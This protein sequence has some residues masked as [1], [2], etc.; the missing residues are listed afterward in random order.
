MR[1]FVALVLTTS[2]IAL[3]ACG[4]DDDRAIKV[5]AA[6][7]LKTAFTAMDSGASFSFAGSDQLAGQIR[8]G[9]RPDVFAAANSKLPDA[10]YKEG[11]VER[12]V[13][14]AR[15]RLVIAVPASGSNVRAIEDLAGAEMTLAIGAGGVPIG[16]YTLSLLA[17][18]PAATSERILANA[19]SREPD[20]SGI[21]GKIAQ[22][23]VDA[24]FV[25]ASDVEAS[26]GRL[27]AIELPAS[28]APVV[29]YKA[30]VVKGTQRRAEAQSFV[31]GL[32]SGDGAKA[33]RTAGLSP[34]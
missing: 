26:D 24:G 14:F 16:I 3:A 11:L 23:A 19:R 25:Y 18:L 6:S 22:G 13:A 33:L 2:S 34:P 5:S 17:E 28:I 7:S 20:V 32:V 31:A 10:L 4:A 8:G 12:P 29:I 27:R 30:A 1:R 21:V 9:A 15:N